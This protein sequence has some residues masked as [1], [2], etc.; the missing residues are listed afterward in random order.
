M[1]VPYRSRSSWQPPP[2]LHLPEHLPV[3]LQGWRPGLV[4]V[5][6]HTGDVQRREPRGMCAEG[7]V[8][9]ECDPRDL[10]RCVCV[11]QSMGPPP[12]Q[13][14]PPDQGEASPLGGRASPGSDLQQSGARCDLAAAQA[15]WFPSQPQT[16]APFIL[17]TVYGVP[18]AYRR[19]APGT[20]DTVANTVDE[21]WL[22][23]SSH[24]SQDH[25]QVNR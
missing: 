6:G 1:L 15:S 20:G 22:S 12:H 2:A 4:L 9:G 23:G 24:S 5:R 3:T 11:R 7:W 10:D 25:K 21:N 14:H 16:G 18:P 13:P 17:S 8:R 19:A